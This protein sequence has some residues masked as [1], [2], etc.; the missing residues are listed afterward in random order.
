[1]DKVNQETLKV[2]PTQHGYYESVE[3]F[4]TRGESLK[5]RCY[6]VHRNEK[7]ENLLIPPPGR[8]GTVTF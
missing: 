7:N 1:M 3:L 8:G 4:I 6:S 5:V 2:E